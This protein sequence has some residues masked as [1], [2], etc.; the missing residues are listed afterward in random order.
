MTEL[1]IIGSA[2]V[3]SV[4]TILRGDEA[5]LTPS[6]GERAARSLI[7]A[8]FLALPLF[9]A[10]QL[11]PTAW[12]PAT[13][14]FLCLVHPRLLRSGLLY[15]LW[16][17]LACWMAFAALAAVSASWSLDPSRSWKAGVVLATYVGV[18]AIIIS[19]IA[20][21]S[22][23]QRDRVWAALV[24]GAI[25]ALIELTA[26]E[27]Y[28]VLAQWDAA[29]TFHKITF[30]G[31]LAAAV[32]LNPRTNEGL[33]RLFL[34]A[35]FAAP[36]LLIGKTTGV[37]LLI[38]ATI[39]LYFLPARQR[40]RLLLASF[41]FYC[42][43]ALSAPV[44]VDWVFGWIDQNFIGRLRSVASFVARLDL[45]RLMAPYILEHPWLGHGADTVRI[46]EFI[47]QHV[48][49]YDLPDLPSAHNMV[50]DQWYELGVVGI[51][52][53]LAI[54]GMTLRDITTSACR[55]NLAAAVIFLGFLVELS[56]D[57]RIWLS[58]VQGAAVFAASAVV[59]M[60]L[61]TQRQ[62]PRA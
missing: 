27:I 33:R 21:L 60:A 51:V 32:I 29:R 58:W 8:L 43:L 40:P 12:A 16:R 31:L 46:S 7:V 24:A 42:L 18:A 53:L 2:G 39:V 26:I 17:P 5:F 50:F 62:S 47:V 14:L 54:L 44:L 20:A 52:S 9:V 35:F 34:L 30:Y 6:G 22:E 59:L 11:S 56:V 37:N 45:W 61:R 10:V 48:K 13:A 57:H 38:L 4:V 15:S 49:Y 55:F 36:T 41:F 19:Y 28:S 23:P 25:I 1:K 3:S